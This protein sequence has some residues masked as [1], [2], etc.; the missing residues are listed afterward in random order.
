[1][2][3]W[4]KEFQYIRIWFH[5]CFLF[6][7]LLLPSVCDNN[8]SLYEPNTVSRLLSHRETLEYEERPRSHLSSRTIIPI[9]PLSADGSSAGPALPKRSSLSRSDVQHHVK[10][11]PLLF[12]WR[13]TLK[14]PAMVAR[15]CFVALWEQQWLFCNEIICQDYRG[16]P[17]QQE[18]NA[19]QTLIC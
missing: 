1:M 10:P 9:N 15:S 14:E 11:P 4:F 16:R 17:L 18:G 12:F 3:W 13:K 7:S 5:G 19:A 6:F 8:Y 2:T